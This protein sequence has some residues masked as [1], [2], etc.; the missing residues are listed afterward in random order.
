MGSQVGCVMVLFPLESCAGSGRH[1]ER[2]R[3]DHSLHSHVTG[4]IRLCV[5]M[6]R[7]LVETIVLKFG[8]TQLAPYC[9]SERSF[10]ANLKLGV[11]CSYLVVDWGP[12]L[13][14]SLI[15]NV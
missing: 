2:D 1:Q 11:P 7:I 9:E 3:A 15:H 14:M 6:S 4:N 10:F 5:H 12:Q 8:L 13:E